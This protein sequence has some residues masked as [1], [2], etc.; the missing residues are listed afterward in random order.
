VRRLY[1]LLGFGLVALVCVAPAHAQ[2]PNIVVVLTDDQRWDTLSVMPATRSIFDVDFKTAVVTTPNC[3]P[4]RVSTLTGEYA[5][6]H[7]IQT[8]QEHEEFALREA[9]SLGPW[10]QAQGYYTGLVGKYLNKFRLNEPV[11]VGWDEFHARVWDEEGRLIDDGHLTFALRH[12]WREGG[13]QHSEV[14]HYPSESA[15]SVYATRVFASRAA[16]FIRHAHDPL[17]NP[18]GK[19]WALLVWPTAPHF[20]FAVERRYADAPVPSWRRPPSFLEADMSDK[21]LEVRRTPLRRAASH[22]F[23][24]ERKQT[25]RMLMSVD[26]LV[27]RVFNT[28]DDFGERE[29]TWGLFTADNGYSWGEHWLSRKLFAFEESI[30][31]PFRMA[32]PGID[33]RTIPDALV[34]N[35]DIAPTLLEIAG[36]QPKASFDGRSLVGLALGT[37]DE[38]FCQRS[39]VIENWEIVRY[40]ALRSP[41]RTYVSW[42]SGRRELYLL[43]RDPYQLTNVA[44]RYPQAVRRLQRRLESLLG[45]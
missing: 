13:V 9:E 22:P 1:R 32:V 28:I 4:S 24:F 40:Q 25:L 18:E 30:R 36:G 23:A 8:N 20:P 41:G 16:A 31:V 44:G 12:W 26:D 19:P 37:G 14:A 2:Q 7:G 39:L 38:C 5:H 11:P 29:R 43:G 33:S 34:A 45:S 27:D 35:I 10:L 3:C 6:N 17:Y 15:P 42:P 21:P